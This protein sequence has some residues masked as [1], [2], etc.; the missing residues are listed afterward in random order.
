MRTELKDGQLIVYDAD[1]DPAVVFDCGQAFRFYDRDGV[2][3]GVAHGKVLCVSGGDALRIWPV[4]ERDADIWRTYFDLDLDY[5]TIKQEWTDETLVKCVAEVK[6]MRLLNQDPFETIISF[7]ISANNNIKRIR[8]IIEKISAAYGE[9]LEFEGEEYYAFPTPAALAAADE[10][11]L[12]S[13]GAGYR[14]PYILNTAKQLEDGSFIENI[15]TL[16]YADAKKELLKLM[17]VGPKVAD[18][19]LLFAFGHKNA[20]PKDVWIRRIIKQEYSEDL[21]KDADIDEFAERTFGKYA[22]IA[23][24]YLFH[25]AR[26]KNIAY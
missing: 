9:K 2:F 11:T 18:C 20:F 4:E 22:G 7:L 23:Q 1:I 8:K 15:K 5:N 19:I 25:Y 26:L 13:C 12:M 3:K 14:A 21:K 17:G 24:Q 6:G 10:E 16:N